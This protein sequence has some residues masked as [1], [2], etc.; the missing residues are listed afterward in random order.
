MSYTRQKRKK[1]TNLHS[2]T[3]INLELTG[4]DGRA[5]LGVVPTGVAFLFGVVSEWNFVRMSE[6]H[7]GG[8]C[9]ATVALHLGIPA[10][11]DDRVH[12]RMHALEE[13][14]CEP[15]PNDFMDAGQI[16]CHVLD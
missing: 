2:S 8:D 11:V 4:I 10:E 3:Q 5:K 9:V 15:V 14:L 1:P 13:H 7:A 12:D 6:A 16:S